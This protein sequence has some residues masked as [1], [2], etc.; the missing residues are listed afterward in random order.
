MFNL[1]MREWICL[2][3]GWA[4]AALIM[5]M[6]AGPATIFFV[7]FATTLASMRALT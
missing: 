1:T 7:G 4:A 3:I 6:G 5:T 2:L